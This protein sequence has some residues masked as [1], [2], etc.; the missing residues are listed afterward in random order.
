MCL[1]QEEID[2]MVSEI[3]ADGNGDIDFDGRRGREP[4][5][6]VNAPSS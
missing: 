6:D 4:V 1:L 2:V 5:Q 3:D